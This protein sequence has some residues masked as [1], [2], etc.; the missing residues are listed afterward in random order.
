MAVICSLLRYLSVFSLVLACFSHF[1]FIFVLNSLPQV[2]PMVPASEVSNPVLR[3]EP[4]RTHEGLPFGSDR[5]A[6]VSTAE[7]ARRIRRSRELGP[8]W[9]GSTCREQF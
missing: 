9:F 5:G 8:F 1:P 2:V 3:Q 6:E 7:G 4:G